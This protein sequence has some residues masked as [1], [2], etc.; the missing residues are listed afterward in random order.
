MS[1]LKCGDFVCVPKPFGSALFR[2]SSGKV[3]TFLGE[4]AVGVP[5]AELPAFADGVLEG[6]GGDSS[7]VGGR[8]FGRL[9]VLCRWIV[10]RVSGRAVLRLVMVSVAVLWVFASAF[11]FARA[12]FAV[13]FGAPNGGL[14]RGEIDVDRSINVVVAKVPIQESGVKVWVV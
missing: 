5:G 10:A 2:Q 4:E 6:G 1:F 12:S 14:R 13:N 7:A 8:V 3:G 9:E 11:V